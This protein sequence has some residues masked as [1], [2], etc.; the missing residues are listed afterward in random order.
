MMRVAAVIVLLALAGCAYIV[1]DC[2]GVTGTCGATS[3]MSTMAPV[4]LSV[5]LGIP[6]I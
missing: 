5:P 4:Q 2:T 1:V 6:S 3:T